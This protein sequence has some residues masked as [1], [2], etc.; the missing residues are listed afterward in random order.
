MPRLIVAFGTDRDR[1]ED[2]GALTSF[3]GIAP[4]TGR[5]GHSE[6]IH[7][8]YACPQ[9]VR[10]T[11]HEFAAHSIQR[12]VWAR[13]YY[14]Q[15]I[16]A[17]KHHHAAVRSLAFKWIRILFRCWKNHTPYDEAIYLRALE[18][19]NSPLD[20]MGRWETVGGFKKFSEKNA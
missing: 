12:S 7:F 15:K 20:T 13:A 6:W 4:V 19:H 17:G 18:N 8:R 11:F 14:D 3:S 1:W 16:G 9:F 10:Q 2:A 5:S